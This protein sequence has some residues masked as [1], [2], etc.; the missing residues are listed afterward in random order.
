MNAVW[1]ALIVLA[2]TIASPALLSYLNGRQLQRAKTEDYARQDA[3]ADRL[4]KRQD[5]VAAQA[6]EAARLLQERQDQA[7]RKAAE[8]AN[9]LLAANERVAAQT[10]EATKATQGQ[11]QQIHTLVNSKLTEAMQGQHEALVRV[12]TTMR[13]VAALK[14]GAG[15]TPLDADATAI[16]T[17]QRKVDE[18]GADLLARQQQTRVADAQAAEAKET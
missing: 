2:G 7:E 18:L 6:R 16:D 10:A 3:V 8:V 9:R 12:V 1:V 15:L 13:E 11:L 17:A 5:A 4:T 14:H